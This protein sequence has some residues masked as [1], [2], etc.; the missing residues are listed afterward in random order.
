MQP[1]SL[2]SFA[3]HRTSKIFSVS[4][5]VKETIGGIVISFFF[6]SVSLM[7]VQAV[8]L[9]AALV[10]LRQILGSPIRTITIKA[11][12]RSNFCL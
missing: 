6:V 10:T 11:E 3:I 2:L 9:E 12:N 8:S 4:L 5:Y 1:S 7:F